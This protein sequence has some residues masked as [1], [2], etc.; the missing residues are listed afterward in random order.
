M[1]ASILP[2]I[3]SFAATSNLH[4]SLKKGLIDLGHEVT[5]VSFGDGFKDFSSDIRLSRKKF[6]NSLSSLKSVFN[7]VSKYPYSFYVKSVK[8]QR[9]LGKLKGYDVV[10]LINEHPIGGLPA[11]EKIQIKRI[12]KINGALFL[13]SSGDDFTNISYYMASDKMKYSIMTPLLKD[14]K[15]NSKY[16]YSLKYLSKSFQNLSR[17][18]HNISDGIIASD[19]DYH[20]PLKNNPKYL[21]MIP[22][23]VVLNKR[24]TKKKIELKFANFTGH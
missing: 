8:F 11:I 1:L 4:N 19:F 6:S 10:Q 18:I 2:S 24:V 12:K 5:L 16:S 17:R 3:P 14:K 23:P 21:G 22:N 20:L 15:L 7:F 9:V 13:L